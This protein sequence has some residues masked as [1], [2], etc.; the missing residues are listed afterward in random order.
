LISLFIDYTDRANANVESLREE[1]TSKRAASDAATA[2]AKASARVAQRSQ[3][4]S[5]GSTTVV[6][7]RRGRIKRHKPR[8]NTFPSKLHFML[9]QAQARGFAAIVSWQPHGRS[10]KIHNKTRFAQEILPHYF[11]RQTIFTSFIRQLCSYNILRLVNA[12]PDQGGYY[13]ELLLRGKPELSLLISLDCVTAAAA[14]ATAGTEEQCNYSRRYD[15]T[16]EP[17]LGDMA[18]MPPDTAVAAVPAKPCPRPP[19]IVLPRSGSTAGNG[20]GQ[21]QLPT[22]AAVVPPPP[23]QLQQ[24]PYHHMFHNSANPL[25]VLPNW[26]FG[27]AYPGPYSPSYAIVPL[28][29]PAAA[30]HYANMVMGHSNGWPLVMVQGNYVSPVM[31]MGPMGPMMPNPMGP[32]MPAPMGPVMPNFFAMPPAASATW[33]PAAAVASPQCLAAQQF[34]A[35]YNH[36]AQ[37]HSSLPP[38]TTAEN[39]PPGAAPSSGPAETLLA[40]AVTSTATVDDTVDRDDE[41][42][43]ASESAAASAN[44]N[45]TEADSDDDS[46]DNSRPMEA[47]TT[48]AKT[49]E[50]VHETDDEETSIDDMAASLAREFFGT[51]NDQAHSNR[52]RPKHSPWT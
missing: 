34:F 36:L 39:S 48:F 3:M 42:S 14:T 38:S 47:S 8:R 21:Q 19:D 26:N 52:K 15:R 28:N 6:G 41:E 2:A 25:A 11:A 7:I 24:P 10:F 29:G 4:T 33:V 43:S 12:G 45:D 35:A 32:M 44:D 17:N 22:T 37:L 27:S 50:N 5:L 23:P 1:L 46:V 30:Q 16:T 18:P 9:E 31:P 49:N 40:P 20:H 51:T 13:H